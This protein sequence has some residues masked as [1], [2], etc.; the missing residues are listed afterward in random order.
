MAT[1]TQ[2]AAE[3]FDMRATHMFQQ[4]G[5][6]LQDLVFHEPANGKTHTFRR[7]KPA[8][9]QEDRPKGLLGN[10]ELPT[11]VIN[12]KTATLK[13]ITSFVD[14]EEIDF[15]KLA[16]NGIID[17]ATDRIVMEIGRK[18]DKLIVDGIGGTAGT[19]YTVLGSQTG[20]TYSQSILES[21]RT[22]AGDN[23][24]P[25]NNMSIIVEPKTMT[26][27]LSQEKVSSMDYTPDRPY[28]TGGRV[29]HTLG[30]NIYEVP[31]L[32]NY[33]NKVTG[34]YTMF[35]FANDAVSLVNGSDLVTNAAKSSARGFDY[36][37]GG[38]IYKVCTSLESAAVTRTILN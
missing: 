4:A 31:E 28:Y 9:S 36:I 20:V 7:W 29:C 13:K 19:D 11:D 25:A 14:Y 2:A 34:K 6:L 17:D 30:F 18:I 24:W 35:A 8:T 10:T 32:K 37:F 5:S 22:F 16:L 33:A 3:S 26:E 21:I 23:H 1:I 12:F 38:M 15:V 27:I